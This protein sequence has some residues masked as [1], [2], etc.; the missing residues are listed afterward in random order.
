MNKKTTM[1]AALMQSIGKYHLKGL[2]AKEIGKLLDVSQRTVQRYLK[3]GSIKQ[4]AEIQTLPQKA[5]TLSKQGFSYTQIA[6]KLRCSKTTV[7]NH[8]KK[9]R[10]QA[11]IERH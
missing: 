2:N 3:A 7:Y 4:N 9:I 6:K 8:I 11:N 5:V 1:Q 10:L